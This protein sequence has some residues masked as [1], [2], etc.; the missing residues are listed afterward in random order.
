MRDGRAE[1]GPF[2][3][4]ARAQT[5]NKHAIAIVSPRFLLSRL[6]DAVNTEVL[7]RTC[8]VLRAAVRGT[9]CRVEIRT[10]LVKEMRGQVPTGAR[11]SLPFH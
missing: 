8:T 1:S 10:S 6:P 11:A 9:H 4:T 2:V 3:F 5:R 7:L